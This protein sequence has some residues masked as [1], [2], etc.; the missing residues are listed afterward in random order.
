MAEIEMLATTQAVHTG[1][2]DTVRETRFDPPHRI[3]NDAS[4]RVPGLPTES[5]ALNAAAVDDVVLERSALAIV[6]QVRLQA[7]QLA[8][9]LR[10]QQND[11]D[12]REAELQAGLAKQ[13]QQQRNGRLWLRERHVELTDRDEELSRLNRTLDVRTGEL[14]AIELNQIELRQRSQEELHARREGLDRREAAIRELELTLDERHRNTLLSAEALVDA[15][16]A[17]DQLSQSLETRSR[18]FDDRHSAVIGMI[19]RFL[20]GETH[21]SIKTNQRASSEGRHAGRARAAGDEDRSPSMFERDELDELGSLL[22]EL[23]NRRTHLAEAETLLLRARSETDELR[24]RLLAER[25]ILESQRKS[26][27]RQLEEQRQRVEGEWQ[28]RRESLQLANDQLELRRA[29]VDQMRGELALVQRET[30]ETRLAAEE[31]LAQ[32]AGAVPSAQLTHQ[33][34]RSRSKLSEHYRL[35]I[36]ELAAQR[37]QLE[38][39]SAQLPEQHEKLNRQKRELEAWLTARQAELEKMAEQLAAREQ[40]IDRQQGHLEQ[41]RIDWDRERNEYQQQVRRRLA[42]LGN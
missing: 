25:A 16:A 14:E 7:Q 39:L 9:H 38:S 30:L 20:K 2:I 42:E 40:L 32:L 6:E 29:A 5:P 41:H 31:L 23:Q 33:L 21:I 1:S 17:H 18:E 36:D 27:R 15:A 35:Q 22:V 26:E 24:E 11:L 8:E 37:R 4:D 3:A 28:K 12:R 13:E 34:A 10:H 19:G